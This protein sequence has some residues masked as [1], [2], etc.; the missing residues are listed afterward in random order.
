MGSKDDQR[1]TGYGGPTSHGPLPGYRPE[2]DGL[3]KAKYDA[4]HDT[5]GPPDS[6]GRL[7]RLGRFVRHLLSEV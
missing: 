3:A 7:A 6:K 2:S 5:N 4:P 1:P